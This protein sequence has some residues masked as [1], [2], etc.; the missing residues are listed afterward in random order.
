MS[1]LNWILL[2][3]F[4]LL[5]LTMGG[6]VFN[7][8]EN[9]AECKARTNEHRQRFG[10]RKDVNLL[11]K[12]LNASQV[13]LLRSL[14]DRL[15]ESVLAADFFVKDGPDCDAWSVYNSFFFSFTAITTIGRFKSVL[16]SNKFIIT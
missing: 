6:Y 2:L 10:V 15:D 7:A 8:L 3:V 4:Y 5:Y 1:L 11:A 14:V 12:H 16:T 9:P 13:V